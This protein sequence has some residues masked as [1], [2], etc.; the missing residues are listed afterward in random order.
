MRKR[1]G[2]REGER[3]SHR[4]REHTP[5]NIGG[6]RRELGLVQRLEILRR[7]N[8]K[9]ASINQQLLLSPLLHGI[10]I[11]AK[12]LAQEGG[13]TDMTAWLEM[14]PKAVA[15]PSINALRSLQTAG[16][17]PGTALQN[18]PPPLPSNPPPLCP[19]DV[20]GL[21]YAL[22]NGLSAWPS[23]TRPE[24]PGPS[25][26]QSWPT[27]AILLRHTW[28]R[29]PPMISSSS[30]SS[31]IVSPSC[32][33]AQKTSNCQ[34][35]LPSRI[36]HPTWLAAPRLHTR[37]GRFARR[38]SRPNHREPPMPPSPLQR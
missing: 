1:Q 32:P 27:P 28:T 8:G 33:H 19:G 11:L 18:D 26:T 29:S 36:L 14:G 22:G 6:Q 17:V 12:I 3:E 15:T 21:F 25:C 10:S 16:K 20:C 24:Q 2:E 7:G 35:T 34:P 13:G 9:R 30:S 4:A 31:S 23:V 38:R 37:A 5:D